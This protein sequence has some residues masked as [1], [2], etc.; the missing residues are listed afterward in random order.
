ML[1]A[2][3]LS[4]TLDRV[5]MIE[6]ALTMRER[7]SASEQRSEAAQKVIR[8]ELNIKCVSQASTAF[9]LQRPMIATLTANVM[10]IAT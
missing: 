8:A 2:A 1:A 10:R 5:H 7:L 9:A 3:G 6:E 4:L